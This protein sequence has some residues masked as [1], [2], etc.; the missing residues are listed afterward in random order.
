MSSE[1]VVIGKDG[2]PRRG[3]HMTRL[4]TFTDAAFAFAA[5]MLAIS[6][7]TVPQNYPELID[8]IKGAPAFVAS[9]AILLLFWR[10]HQSWSDRYGL[11]DM[12]SVLLT[13]G[14][15]IV[16][17]IY[18]YPLK[19]LFG[20]AFFAISGGWLPSGFRLENLHE[21]RVVLT[22]YSTGFG[23][24]CLLVSALYFYAASRNQQLQMTVRELFDTR[25]ESLAWLIVALVAV[26]SVV[27]A[28]ALPAAWVALSAWIYCSLAVFGPLFSRA[29]NKVWQ[30]R[31]ASGPRAA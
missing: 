29:Q 26:L 20:A 14:L 21:F 22:I 1:T 4:E 17:M 19:I 25:A 23:L 18:V 15:I 8:A 3:R 5:A 16:L 31:E 30:R 11:E 12:P 7:D 6:I 24:M 2:H 10:A 27:L 28:W 9:F 13:G